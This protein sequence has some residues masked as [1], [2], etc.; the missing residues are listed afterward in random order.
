[1]YVFDLPNNIPLRFDEIFSTVL[2][3]DTMKIMKFLVK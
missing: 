3:F 2:I 1:M